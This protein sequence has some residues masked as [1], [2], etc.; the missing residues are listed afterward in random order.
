MHLDTHVLV[1]LYA[2][3]RDRFP[4]AARARLESGHLAVSPIVRLELQ[5]LLEVGRVRVD[6]HALLVDLRRRA[7]V[8]VSATP[9][10]DVVAAA[11]PL[12]WTRDPFDR[13]IAAQ[14]LVEGVPLLTAERTIRQHL[15][16][17]VWD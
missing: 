3:A 2:G 13:L 6:P 10:G 7:G 17:A 12:S 15:A 14:A 4:P 11:Q 16:L 8:T 1:W 5:Y 9:F